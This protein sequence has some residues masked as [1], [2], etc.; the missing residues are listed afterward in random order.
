MSAR[1]VQTEPMSATGHDEVLAAIAAIAAAADLDLVA[2]VDVGDPISR[3]TESGC[4]VVVDFTHPDAV[5]GNVEYLVGHGIH[6]VVGT[7]GWTTDRLAQVRLW[8]ADTPK[9]GVLVAPNF[10]IGA[11]LM[12]RFAAQAAPYFDSVEIVELHHPNKA[13]AP[14]GTATATARA[15]R[16]WTRPHI[17]RHGQNAGKV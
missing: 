2:T 9:T 3:L 1:I 15:I 17:H 11:V 14:S 7:T 12:M 4:E 6:A 10:A 8:L 5:M 13:D 16:T